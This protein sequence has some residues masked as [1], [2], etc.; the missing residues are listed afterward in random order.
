MKRNTKHISAALLVSAVM[1]M[2]LSSCGGFYATST[3]G[4][5]LY[6]DNY[7]GTPGYDYFINTPPPP[8]PPGAWG[9]GYSPGYYPPPFSPGH[10]KPNQGNPGGGNSGSPDFGSGGGNRP[11]SGA[12]N[13]P[14]SRPSNGGYRGNR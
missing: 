5:D 8:P 3:V 1:I 9:P 12:T 13:N 11:S 14:A 4:P 2:T 6:F 10:S 7:Y